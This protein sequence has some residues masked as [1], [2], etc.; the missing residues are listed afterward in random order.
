MQSLVST[1]LSEN[2]SKKFRLR[3]TFQSYL[4]RVGYGNGDEEGYGNRAILLA[5][6]KSDL[7]RSRVVS[8]EGKLLSNQATQFWLREDFQ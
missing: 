2:N 5:G 8:Q 6:N 7:E 3:L 1:N 4:E